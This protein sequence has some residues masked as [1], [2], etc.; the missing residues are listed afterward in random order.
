MK[1]RER[2]GYTWF[3][4]SVARWR[5]RLDFKCHRTATATVADAA[6]FPL[7]RCGNC[8][9]VGVEG[10]SH[11]CVCMCVCVSGV[12]KVSVDR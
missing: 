10:G 6:A 3:M 5:C 11:T 12:C 7:R 2:D 1:G 4:I 9:A 8:G